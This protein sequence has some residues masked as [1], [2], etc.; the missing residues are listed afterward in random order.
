MVA[1]RRARSGGASFGNSRTT[2]GRSHG[3]DAFSRRNAWFSVKKPPPRHSG[4]SAYSRSGRPVTTRAVSSNSSASTAAVCPEAGVTTL[5]SSTRGVVM[6]TTRF[7]ERFGLDHPIMAAPMGGLSDSR[8]TAAVSEA[9]ALGSFQA[10]HP[11]K[12]GDWAIEQIVETRAAT[13]RPFA[14]GFVTEFVRFAPARFDAVLEQRVPVIALELR[15]PRV[16]DRRRA[17]HRLVGDLPGP[18]RAAGHRGRRRGHRRARDAGHGGG[19]AHRHDGPAPAVGFGARP[20]PRRTGARGRRRGER[21]HAR[22]RARDGRR[23]GVD[24]IG[25]HRDHRSVARARP[26]R[27]T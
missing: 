4:G 5:V 26:R 14:V 25:V 19:R 17:R 21:T 3:G 1:S 6:L 11:T 13:G 22:G 23:R 2:S 18:D 12:G 15:Q 7:T 27:R 16:V 24:R 8:L 9:G 20:L 10:L